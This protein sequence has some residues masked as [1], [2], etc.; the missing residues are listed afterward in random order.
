M[1]TAELFAQSLCDDFGVPP[2]HFVSKIV[3]VINERVREY[4]DQVLP[5][6][7]RSPEVIKGKMDSQ[8]DDESRAM[9]RVFAQMREGSEETDSGEASPRANGDDHVKDEPQDLAID[10]RSS[11][12]LD[13]TPMTVEEAMSLLH[14]DVHEDYRILIKVSD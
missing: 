10:Y 9:C 1:V 2:I 7:A 3:T 4:K 11:I 13:E 14:P 8:G 12:D 6:M 5:I